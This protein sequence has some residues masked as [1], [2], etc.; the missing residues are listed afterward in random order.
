MT[1][2]AAV[3]RINTWTISGWTNLGD[4][5]NAAPANEDVP[6][7]ALDIGEVGKGFEQVDM[8]ASS[9]L[10][11]LTIEHKALISTMGNYTPTIRA[12]VPGYIDAYL[13]KVRSD[14]LLN[15]AL[16]QPI[17]I[18]GIRRDSFD[19]Y[20]VYYFGIIFTHLWKVAF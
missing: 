14:L 9:G 10:A 19:F 18:A 1:V 13:T 16:A 4:S 2:A 11:T 20:G 5:Y 15:D 17:V 8:A 3:T 7:L 6:A 12:L